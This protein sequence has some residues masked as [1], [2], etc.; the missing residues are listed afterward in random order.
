MKV[1]KGCYLGVGDPPDTESLMRHLKWFGETVEWPIYRSDCRFEGIAVS[2]GVY[3]VGGRINYYGWNGWIIEKLDKA[4]G[5]TV[6][7]QFGAENSYE[8]AKSVCSDGTYIYIAGID[9]VLNW[10]LEKRRLTDGGIEWV[11]NDSI[12]P[13]DQPYN[14]IAVDETYIYM[15]GTKGGYWTLIKKLKS[16]G[17][18][19]WRITEGDSENF[20]LGVCLYEDSIFI[21]GSAY[22]NLW[23]SERR[24]KSDGSIVWTKTSNSSPYGYNFAYS[25]C[26]D[27]ENV[28]ISGA[29]EQPGTAPWGL[30]SR[31]FLD[32]DLNY[33]V[34]D[35]ASGYSDVAFTNDISGDYIIVGGAYSMS[36]GGLPRLTK[37]NKSDGSNVWERT[38]F[39]A[40]SYSN[41]KGV[42]VDG[43]YI[44]CTG[45]YHSSLG[46]TTRRLISTGD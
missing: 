19:V 15:V 34:M 10:R 23:R 7:V 32:G 45:C 43:S 2:D 33:Y 18:T 4:T 16:T 29:D 17:E 12:P 28:F 42:K 37:V 30:E 31:K 41:I 26:T 6:W 1:F 44:Y 46:M 13:N 25:V 20:A 14:G 27:G 40:E 21:V 9:L 38:N 39:S 24:N 5:S 35:D 22:P 36:P 11:Q 8:Y 3:V